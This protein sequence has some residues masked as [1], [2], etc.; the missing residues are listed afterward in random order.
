M[1]T[2]AQNLCSSCKKQKRTY[3]CEECSQHFC[4]EC[5][6][7][8]EQ[9]LASKFDRI[10][11]SHDEIRQIL[12]DQKKDLNKHPS[13][14]KIDQWERDSKKAIEQKANECRQMVRGY[15]NKV[16]IVLE[17]QLNDIAKNFTSIRQKNLFNDTHVKEFQEKM[18][19]LL[20]ELNNSSAILIET[21]STSLIANIL[22]KYSK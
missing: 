4:S 20:K 11:Y 9:E 14:M 22:V 18:E 21:Q 15:A 13:M 8:H 7:R 6:P 12:S 10:E 19:N 3:K 16:L 5:L 1:A 2:A 17:N